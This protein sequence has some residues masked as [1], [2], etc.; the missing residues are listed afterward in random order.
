MRLEALLDNGLFA[1]TTPG[2]GIAVPSGWFEVEV[3]FLTGAAGSLEVSV[4]QGAF[5]GLVGLA[6]S[7]VTVARARVGKVAGGNS[8]GT[9]GSL[10]LDLYGA[11]R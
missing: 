10:E 2:S 1:Q 3:R 11:W 9:A 7:T 8:A 6:N 5:A 4:D